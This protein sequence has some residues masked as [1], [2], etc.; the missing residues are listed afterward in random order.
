M[1]GIKYVGVHYLGC[2]WGVYMIAEGGGSTYGHHLCDLG[3][4]ERG[5]YNS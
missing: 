4:D 5:I 3:G 1:E 2:V